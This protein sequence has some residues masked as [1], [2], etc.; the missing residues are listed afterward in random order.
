MEKIEEKRNSLCYGSPKEEEAV[1]EVIL[2]FNK[3]KRVFK[4][5]GVQIE[6]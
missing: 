1:N 3:L 4:S 6:E 5:A 2:A